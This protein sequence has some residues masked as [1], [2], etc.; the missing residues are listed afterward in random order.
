MGLYLFCFVLFCFVLFCFVFC[1]VLFCF[2]LFCF[3]F[4]FCFCLFVCLFVCC[5]FCCCSLVFVFVFVF[6]FLFFAQVVVKYPRNSLNHIG[7]PY[8]IKAK[9]LIIPNIGD[10]TPT[11]GVLLW[12]FDPFPWQPW[13][14][15]FVNLRYPIKICY[16]TIVPNCPRILDFFL[17]KCLY[18][19]WKKQLE[20]VVNH[21]S[22]TPVTMATKN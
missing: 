6:V 21:F 19:V 9:T 12:F 15:S 22:S 14:L 3:C 18:Q 1:F 17:F 20:A 10:D 7:L 13:P 5:F 8:Q 11:I 4:C 2:V 16:T